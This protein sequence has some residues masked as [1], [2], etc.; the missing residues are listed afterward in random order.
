MLRF[1]R[2][3][4]SSMTL[5]DK[6]SEA[7]FAQNK[8]NSKR[9]KNHTNKMKWA[10]TIWILVFIRWFF[11]SRCAE[12]RP[13]NTPNRKLFTIFY[14]YLYMYV[15]LHRYRGYYIFSLFFLR[16]INDWGPRQNNEDVDF[17]TQHRTLTTVQHYYTKAKLEVNIAMKRPQRQTIDGTAKN[18]TL[19]CI[20]EWRVWR[21]EPES[22]RE[23]EK[24]IRA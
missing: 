22:V 15:Y 3:C 1:G 18:V 20:S 14:I 16:T 17:H 24:S 21:R 12:L 6:R 5:S 10:N 4:N 11:G 13:Q 7:Q 19:T 8:K 23:W 2:A 9:K